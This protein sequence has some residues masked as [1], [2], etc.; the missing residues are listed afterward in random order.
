M[1]EQIKIVNTETGE[2]QTIGSLDA[3]TAADITCVLKT[4]NNS[5]K[6]IADSK[7]EC[8]L[9]DIIEL[10]D[11]VDKTLVGNMSPQEMGIKVKEI[12]KSEAEEP[13]FD[14]DGIPNNVLKD[15]QEQINSI[16]EKNKN[17]KKT[18]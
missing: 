16:L 11:V 17:D 9:V 8:C 14:L 15:I 1:K 12:T 3:N 5:L 13:L 18:N 4:I 2:I 10:L 6:D 7:T